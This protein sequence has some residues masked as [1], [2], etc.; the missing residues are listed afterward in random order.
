MPFYVQ[1]VTVK[2]IDVKMLWENLYLVKLTKSISLENNT[3]IVD[4]YRKTAHGIKS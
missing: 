3:K 2:Y 1:I 4:N